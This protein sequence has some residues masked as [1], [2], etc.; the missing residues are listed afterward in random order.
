LLQEPRDPFVNL[1]LT[2]IDAAHV[3]VA[4]RAN[5][6]AREPPT[7]AVVMVD[8]EPGLVRSADLALARGSAFEGVEVFAGHPISLVL[9]HSEISGCSD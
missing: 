9:A 1:T 6:A 4:L 8:I 2:G 5:V 3:C 7:E